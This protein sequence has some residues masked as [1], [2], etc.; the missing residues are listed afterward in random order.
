MHHSARRNRQ[1]A[2]LMMY[3]TVESTQDL[4]EVKP[5]IVLAKTSRT[6]FHCRN[7]LRMNGQIDGFDSA[8]VVAG[9]EGFTQARGLDRIVE[10]LRRHTSRSMDCPARLRDEGACRDDG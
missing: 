7:L 8:T 5:P 9:F 2:E 3:R 6:L 1:N 4:R 10:R